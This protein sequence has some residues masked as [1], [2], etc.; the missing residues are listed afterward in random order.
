MNRKITLTSIPGIRVGHATNLRAVT[1]CTVILGDKGLVAG[2]DVG[3]GASGTREM[4]PCRPEH[5]VDRIDGLCLAGGSAYG[6]AAASGVMRYLER[7][8]VG[9]DTHSARVPIVPAAI[10]YDL[11]IGSSTVRPDATMGAAACRAASRK[12]V[13]SGSVGA[14]TGATVGKLF[15]LGRA[16]K[17]GVGNAGVRLP[18]SSGGATVAVL[19]VVNAFGDVRAFDGSIAAG[20]RDISAG[21]GSRKKHWADT[22]KRMAA[23]TM[24]R[25]SSSNTMLVVVATDARLSRVQASRI[26]RQCQDG[27]A[28]CISPAH[29]RFDGDI[30]FVLSAGNR[31]FDPD[32][33]AVAACRIIGDAVIDA[34]QSATTLGKVPALQEL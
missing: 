20:A 29:T 7:R 5:L 28:R 32:C 18:A 24:K 3:G 26:A 33:L 16:T 34:V 10:I 8:G 12:P 22:D 4:D 6:L 19:A 17:S 14:G 23:G 21:R 15:G 31:R 25:F 1:G 9:F 27:V 30:V 13:A 2:S 11:G